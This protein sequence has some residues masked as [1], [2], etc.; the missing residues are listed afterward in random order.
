MPRAEQEPPEFGARFMKYLRI[1]PQLVLPLIVY[2]EKKNQSWFTDAI[3]Q[4]LLMVFAGIIPAALNKD[5]LRK[6]VG[7]GDFLRNKVFQIIY[8]FRP[9]ET[10][11]SLLL[12]ATRQNTYGE[13]NVYPFSLMVVV[14]PVSTDGRYPD[15]FGLVEIVRGIEAQPVTMEELDARNRDIQQLLSQDILI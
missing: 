12:H 14:E 6:D 10:K 1:G 4:Q 5:E 9:T 13:Y 2:I 8:T 3:F 7:K 11:H 15:F